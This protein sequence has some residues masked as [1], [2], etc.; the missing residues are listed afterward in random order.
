MK[1]LITGASGQIGK[2]L[3]TQLADTTHDI[4]A[5]N[6]QQLDI[7]HADSTRQTLH[8]HQPD[9]VINLA[10]YTAV[11]AAETNSD[12]AFAINHQ[13]AENIGKASAEIN[14]AIIH[15]STDYVFSGEK[16]SPYTED[17]IPAPLN[18]Y[19]KSKLAGEIAV[20]NSNPK[21]LILRTS[22]VFS[23]EQKNFFRTML[24]LGK[25]KKTISV[26]NDQ[27]GGPTYA[28]DIA[29]ALIT[30][31]HQ[32]KT[33]TQSDWGTYHYTGEPYATWFEFAQQIFQSAK[34]NDGLIN[35]E[36]IPIPSSQYP[37]AAIR[38]LN[39]CLDQQ[40]ITARFTIQPSNWRA[41]IAELLNKPA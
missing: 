40:K 30:I 36:L 28:P 35:P 9:L 10:A 12:Q 14:A 38:P 8:F 24:E 1:I 29:S 4:I 19:G 2:H 31:C 33:F 3:T 32:I 5:L 21:H 11:D 6:H 39:S 7:V 25:T 41:A 26:V 22:W 27:K 37:T 20:K 23:N 17:D 18:V 16:K 13:G 15:L 34:Q